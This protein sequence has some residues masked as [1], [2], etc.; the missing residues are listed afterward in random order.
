[1]ATGRS[2]G[3]PQLSYGRIETL[4]SF[5]L[6]R[7]ETVR[8]WEDM[9]ARIPGAVRTLMTVDVEDRR[10][11]HTN[12]AMEVPAQTRTV[13]PEGRHTRWRMLAEGEDRIIRVDAEGWSGAAVR[14]YGPDADWCDAA[15]HGVARAARKHRTRAGRIPVPGTGSGIAGTIALLAASALM[16]LAGKIGEALTLSG[17]AAA[18]VGLTLTGMLSSRGI[19]AAGPPETAEEGREPEPA[20]T[21]NAPA[22]CPEEAHDPATGE[23]ETIH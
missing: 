9:E 18:W 7:E 3:G 20:E 5:L 2:A 4:R 21:E 13:L 22:W 17:M 19:L 11:G 1:M 8:M 16:L 23:A 6:D 10:D 12:L 14:A 15:A